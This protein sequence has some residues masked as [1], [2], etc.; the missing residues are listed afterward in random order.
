MPQTRHP[1]SFY[2]KNF[3]NDGMNG[4]I[5]TSLILYAT[6]D[7]TVKYFRHTRWQI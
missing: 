7:C 1:F 6:R 3:L 5:T 4:I 2:N